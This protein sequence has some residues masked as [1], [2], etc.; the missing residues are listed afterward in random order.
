MRRFPVAPDAVRDGRALLGPADT[1]HLTRVLRLGVGARVRLYDGEGNEYDARVT[2]AADDRVE[3]AVETCRPHAGESPLEVL[4]LQGFLKE[5]K[6]DRLV[7][8]ATELGVARFVPVFGERSVARP[9]GRRLEARQERWAKIA[10]EALKQCRRGR[11]PAIGPPVDM[12]GALALA[13][14]C[15]LKIAFWEEARRPLAGLAA[16]ETVRRVA[17]LMG[18]EGGLTP[19]EAS[20]AEAAGFAAVSLGPRILRAET[21]TVAACA[22][23]QHRWGDV[24]K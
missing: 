8:Q 14:G 1:R 6:M 11:V 17:V 15:D 4:L 2:G 3:L 13:D 10:A 16:S 5:K 12:A 24:G 7:R 22:L 23:V 19:A 18:P 20:A 9:E 21:A